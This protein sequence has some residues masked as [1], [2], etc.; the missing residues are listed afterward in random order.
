MADKI[1]MSLENIIKLLLSNLDFGVSDV[2]IQQLFAEFGPLKQATVHYDHSG[3]SLGTAHVHFER[4]ADALEARKQYNGVPLDCCPLH[5]Q[6]LNS[7]IDTMPRPVRSVNRG[8]VPTNR[9]SGGFGGS[10]GTQGRSRGGNQRPGRRTGRHSKR[11]IS[12]EELDTQLDTYNFMRGPKQLDDKQDAYRAMRGTQHLNT[13]KDAY[14]SMRDTKRMN[15]DAYS[16]M[17]DT[18]ELDS[19]LDADSAMKDTKDLDGQNDFEEMDALLDE[20]DAMI[21]TS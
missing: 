10:G 19:Q 4:K 7:Q 1:H 13:Q 18:E 8:C 6:V 20:D 11:H 5:I 9:G 16:S 17:R 12:A 21:G 3:R 14:N 2:D 15:K